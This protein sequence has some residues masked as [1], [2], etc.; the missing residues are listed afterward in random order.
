MSKKTRIENT[1]S[2]DAFIRVNKRL[3]AHLQSLD[4][5]A[6]VAELI[7][8]GRNSKG[9]WFPF[10]MI[11]VEACLYIGRRKTEKAKSDLESSGIVETSK[12]SSP[13]VMHWR[14]NYDLIAEILDTEPD[15]CKLNCPETPFQ[16]VQNEQIDL[17]KTDNSSI[18]KE[19][20]SKNSIRS[21]APRK[22][23]QNGGTPQNREGS[24]QADGWPSWQDSIQYFDDLYRSESGQ[25][26]AWTGRE[27]KALKELQKLASLDQ[28]KAKNQI[29]QAMAKDDKFWQGVPPMPSAFLS[30]WNRLVKKF[31]PPP[32]PRRPTTMA[33]M[34]MMQAEEERRKNGG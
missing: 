14:I 5:A 29:R 12:R 19:N 1:I 34:K 33:E 9:G 8:I 24:N 16:N 10:G 28:V 22:T 26:P 13:P 3:V 11:E 21:T 2:P 27:M 17:C 20:R 23:E 6:L 7:F 18:V 15:L 25:P 31:E 30:H 32:P 4:A